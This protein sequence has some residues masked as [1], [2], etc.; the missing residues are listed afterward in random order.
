MLQY[1]ATTVSYYAM[2]SAGILWIYLLTGCQSDADKKSKQANNTMPKINAQTEFDSDSST[3]EV[4]QFIN[5]SMVLAKTDTFFFGE[6]E[7]GFF[8]LGQDEDDS[9]LTKKEGNQHA[10][11]HADPAREF[12]QEVSNE[13]VA[14]NLNEEVERIKIPETWLKEVGPAKVQIKLLINRSGKPKDFFVY[15]SPDLRITKAILYRLRNLR[16]RPAVLDGK[17]VKAWV[18]FSYQLKS[19]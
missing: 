2:L 18:N 6:F 14:L 9:A 3:L 10:R 1:K 12:M 7:E 19:A 8:W 11:A 5:D 16:Y 4:E 17:P 15:K 13:P